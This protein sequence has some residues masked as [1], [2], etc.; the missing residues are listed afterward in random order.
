MELETRHLRYFLALADERSF[1]RASAHLG[2]AQSALSTQVQRL[3]RHFGVP[4]V[5]RGGRRLVLTAAG[6]ELATQARLILATIRGAEKSVRAQ[7]DVVVLR[8]GCH[9]SAWWPHEVTRVV[10]EQASGLRVQTETLDTADAVRQLA[11]GRLDLCVGADFPFLP[12]TPAAPLRFRELL[13]EPVWVAVPA[14]HPHAHAD[15]VPLAALTDDDWLTQPSGSYL[16]RGL[17]RLCQDA[18]FAPRILA[19]GESW[20]LSIL[21]AQGRGVTL[22]SPL[23]TASDGFVIR[24]TAPL[25]WRRIF[26]AWRPEAVDDRSVDVVAAAVPSLHDQYAARVAGYPSEFR[27]T[28]G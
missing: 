12:L 20:D 4:L 28:P 13:R 18:G 7:A 24:P 9:R 3:E 14:G 6:E 21:L 27:T 5:Q 26:A 16:R 1:T 2:I 19:C 10:E 23:A 11:E 15:L 25:A 17:E 22:C 8:V